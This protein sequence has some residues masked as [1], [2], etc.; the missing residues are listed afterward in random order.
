[1]VWRLARCFSNCFWILLAVSSFL[2]SSCSEPVAVAV[3]DGIEL[4]SET[5]EGEASP[6]GEDPAWDLLVALRNRTFARTAELAVGRFEERFR[7][8]TEY[9]DEADLSRMRVISRG[10]DWV[11][12]GAPSDL[13]SNR[14]IQIRVVK[15]RDSWKIEDVRRRRGTI[16]SRSAVP[17]TR[18]GVPVS[19]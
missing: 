10:A 1:M 5:D 7:E 9:A 2:L 13:D 18:A 12:I 4:A 3:H 11:R 19:R 14:W 16:S 6:V 17:E 8:Q 15:W